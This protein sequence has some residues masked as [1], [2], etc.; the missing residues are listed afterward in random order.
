MTITHSQ[1]ATLLDSASACICPLESHQ[2]C[3][4][5]QHIVSRTH[6]HHSSNQHQSTK[7]NRLGPNPTSCCKGTTGRMQATAAVQHSQHS[8][9]QSTHHYCG[10]CM[11]SLQTQT[12]PMHT[13]GS[14]GWQVPA[15]ALSRCAALVGCPM[16]IHATYA[17]SCHRS[18][19]CNSRRGPFAWPSHHMREMKQVMTIS[20][21]PCSVS[22]ELLSLHI[23][24][25]TVPRHQRGRIKGY[26]PQTRHSAALC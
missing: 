3:L 12:H 15:R 25:H 11:Y 18:K 23:H 21:S 19:L 16:D 24:M 22:H 8:T 4:L 7:Q 20:S 26:N 5:R 1:D 14:S 6:T 10:P 17:H 9:A 2:P 13:A